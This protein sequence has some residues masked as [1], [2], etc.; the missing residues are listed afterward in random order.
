MDA[1]LFK[2]IIVGGGPV[3]LYIAHALQRERTEFMLLVKQKIINN[4]SG[5]L[6]FLWPRT[7]RLLDQIGLLDPLRQA[8]LFCIR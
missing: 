3:G 8:S 6:L 7:V 4:P 2:V 5:Q 1:E